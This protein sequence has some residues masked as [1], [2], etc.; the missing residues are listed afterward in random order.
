LARH[1][2]ARPLGRLVTDAALLFLFVGGLWLVADRA[3]FA[4]L[5]FDAAI[6][7][8]TAVHF[9]FAG[10]ALPLVAGQLARRRPESR[11]VARVSV[12]VVLGVPAV[13]AGIVATQLGAGEAFEAAAGVAL[14]LA[15]GAVGALHVQLAGAEKT[16]PGFAR[17]LLGIAGAAL[18]VAMLLAAMYALRG[19]LAGAPWLGLP[20]MRAWHGTINAVGFALCA[21]L[22]WRLVWRSGA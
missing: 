10:F 1:G 13:A 14:A 3:G 4:P 20:Q 16:L 15:G 5:R 2:A 22:G 11:F 17:A 21:V 8:L 12:G 9:H 18:I 7:A 6:V 19:S